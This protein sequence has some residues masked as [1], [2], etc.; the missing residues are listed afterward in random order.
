MT[1]IEKANELNGKRKFNTS[2][3]YKTVVDVLVEMAEWKEQEMMEMFRGFLHSIGRGQQF[4]RF[5]RLMK[6]K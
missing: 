2:Y 5:E 1:N 3:Q 6:G 4:G